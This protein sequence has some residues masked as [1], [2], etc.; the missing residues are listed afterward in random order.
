MDFICQKK[1]CI[2]DLHGGIFT[3]EELILLFGFIFSQVKFDHFKIQSLNINSVFQR[4][5]KITFQEFPIVDSKFFDL[6]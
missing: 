2:S 1:A 3:V 6:N 4:I 5:K